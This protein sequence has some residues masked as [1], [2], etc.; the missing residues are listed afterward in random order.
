M[1]YD[2]AATPPRGE[3]CIRGPTVFSG[4]YKE[5]GLTAESMGGGAGLGARGVGSWGGRGRCLFC[6]LCASR[7]AGEWRARGVRFA[8]KRG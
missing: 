1:G 3:V 4:Y 8:R 5:E 2:P 7:F 6:A